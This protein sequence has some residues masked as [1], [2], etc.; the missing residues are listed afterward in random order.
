ML[1]ITLV[2]IPGKKQ[3]FNFNEKSRQTRQILGLY[4]T[5]GKYLYN[6]CLSSVPLVLMALGHA[7]VLSS[8]LDEELKFH[9]NLSSEVK[10]LWQTYVHI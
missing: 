4:L 8:V 1:F 6:P 3:T 5:G 10:Q 2:D 7:I 9:D